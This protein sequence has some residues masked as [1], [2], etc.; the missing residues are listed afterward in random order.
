MND[1]SSKPFFIFIFILLIEMLIV[2]ATYF[3]DA[4]LSKAGYFLRRNVLVA[5]KGNTSSFVWKSIHEAIPMARHEVK[6]WKWGK[7]ISIP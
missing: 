6:D 3:L 1:I 4:R 7:H 5:K 2:R